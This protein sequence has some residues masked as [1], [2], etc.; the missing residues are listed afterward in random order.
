VKQNISLLIK[1]KQVLPVLGSGVGLGGGVCSLVDLA[2]LFGV[3]PASVF[4]EFFVFVIDFRL[5]SVFFFLIVS[6][7]GVIERGLII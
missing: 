6:F 3:F 2:L 1:K 4:A 5:S 7:V